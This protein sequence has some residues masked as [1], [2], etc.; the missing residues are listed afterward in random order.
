[1]SAG[2]CS[3]VP[4]KSRYDLPMNLTPVLGSLRPG[5]LL[6]DLHI[7]TTCSDGWWEPG[8]LAE[9]A[10]TAGLDAIAITDH[11]DI[12]GGFLV[13]EYCAR[14]GLP[15]TV[16]T[17]CEISARERGRDIHVIGLGLHDEIRPW[18]TLAATVEAILA[19]GAIPV[20]PHPTSAHHG[21][22]SFEQILALGVPVAIE[23]FNASIGDLQRLNPL[24]RVNANDRA[25][26]FYE[27]HCARLLGATGGT[28]AHFRTVG[29]GLTAWEGRELFD[30]IR[31]SR[32]VVVT[33]GRREELM[34]WDP[35]GYVRGLRSMGRRRRE[36][37]K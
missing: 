9:A 1:M 7:H 33:T 30:A 24:Q 23:I 22:P 32:T 35:I 36:R 34:P 4:R 16:F 29:R 11:D 21:L 13:R 17:G 15:L 27:T 28:D 31:E 26:H 14:R 18:Q 3:I 25:L 5:M 12:R 6:A 8:P 10:I 37:W 20:M 19:Q 2:S